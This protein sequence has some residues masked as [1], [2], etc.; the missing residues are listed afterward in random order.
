M[1][2]E[3]ENYTCS[4]FRVFNT[5]IEAII[6]KSF[7]SRKEPFLSCEFRFVLFNYLYTCL[8]CCFIV[9]VLNFTTVVDRCSSIFFCYLW[10]RLLLKYWPRQ[11]HPPR[12]YL[13]TKAENVAL[14]QFVALHKDLQ[15]SPKEW[16][17]MRANHKY[18][19]EA[20]DYIKKVA[21]TAYLRRGI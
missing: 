8:E 19:N 5:K 9:R 2:F 17:S 6:K 7:L 10:F 21:G 4:K 20:A 3:E 13:W 1:Y 12:K 18:W 14:V 16:P 15:D 11:N